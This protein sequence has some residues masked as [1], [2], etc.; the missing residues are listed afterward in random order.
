[1]A[2]HTSDSRAYAGPNAKRIAGWHQR[3]REELDRAKDNRGLSP[4]VIGQRSGISHNTIYSILAETRDPQI[5]TLVQICDALG[6]SLEAVLTG[7]NAT[8]IGDKL[9]L[10]CTVRLLGVTELRD[11][12]A[13][14]VEP[15]TCCPVNAAEYG[16]KVSAAKLRD[17]SMVDTY[18]KDDIILYERTDTAN[19]G[20]VVLVRIGNETLLR[21]FHPRYDNKGALRAAEYVPENTRWPKRVVEEGEDAQILGVVRGFV[22]AL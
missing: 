10:N 9:K 4:R 11:V 12:G 5:Q 8:F 2:K 13:P 6:V 1:M 15:F 19:P 7:Q 20:D 16:D 17:D 18:L 14:K 21:S 3:L 22:R